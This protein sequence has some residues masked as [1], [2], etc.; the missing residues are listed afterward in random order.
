VLSLL[1][2]ANIYYNFLMMRTTAR[3][4]LVGTAHFRVM[5]E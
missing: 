5:R 3:P 2:I 1:F 4:S